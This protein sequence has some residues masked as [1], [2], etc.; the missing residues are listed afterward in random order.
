MLFTNRELFEKFRP[1]CERFGRLGIVAVFSFLANTLLTVAFAE[2]GR[3]SPELAFAI[4]LVLVFFVNFL[5]TRFWV[6]ADRVT[7]SN[8]WNHLV[9]C[10]MV[11]GVFRF[12]EWA[13]FALLLRVLDVSYLVLLVCVL[14]VSF[15]VKALIYDRLV[16]R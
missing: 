4:V 9:K 12:L 10:L 16:F 13:T 8:L 1:I 7:E 14:V 15:A 11:S 6:F 3:L 2:L 5:L